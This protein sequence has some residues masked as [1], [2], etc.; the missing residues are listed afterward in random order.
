MNTGDE[1]IEAIA[2]AILE[3]FAM[4]PRAADS[5][6]GVADVW[7]ETHPHGA[8]PEMALQ[9]L[10]KLIDRGLVHSVSKGDGK[11][12]FKLRLQ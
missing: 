12:F 11:Q 3:W 8:T 7:L 6:K 5:V 2:D 4:Y 1:D 10:E 9:A